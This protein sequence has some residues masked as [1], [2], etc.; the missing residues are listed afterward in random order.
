[1]GE[2]TE[3]RMSIHLWGPNDGWSSNE[4]MIVIFKVDNV[5]KK[6][7]VVTPPTAAL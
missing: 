6:I 5:A 4:N 1:M 2:N 3:E 7:L